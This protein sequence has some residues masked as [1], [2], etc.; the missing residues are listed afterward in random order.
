MKLEIL[1][2]LEYDKFAL[3]HK[4]I[5]I[6]QLSGWGKL[7]NKTGWKSHL[8][9]FKKNNEIICATLLLEKS[10]PIK[11]SLFYAPRGFLIDSDDFSLLNKFT[12]EVVKYI[13]L[14]KGFMLKIDPNVIYK[15]RNAKNE[16]IETNKNSF[17]NYCES[18]FKHFGFTQDF[19]TLQPRNLCRF[20]LQNSYEETLN[21]FQKSTRK[22]ILKAEEMGVNT[23]V[24]K[25]N[26]M[27]EF[28]RLLNM[29]G[30]KN[31]FIVR[32]KWYYELMKN[33]FNDEVVFYLTY[34]DV[35]KYLK[36]LQ[37]KI[38]ET[39]EKLDELKIKFEKYNVG[40]KLKKEKQN[41]E[42]SLIKYTDLL[43][44]EKEKYKNKDVVNIGALMSVFTGED[45]ITFMSGTDPEYKNFYPKYSYYNKHMEDS[46]KRK[47]K[48][49]NFYGISGNLEPN[50][51]Y[52]NIY[53]IKKGFNPDIVEL[54]GE[55]DFII[56]KFYYVLYKVALQAYK[57]VKKIKK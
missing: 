42:S 57:I 3:K 16:V 51:K 12:K 48:Y 43:K 8:V 23:K 35:K 18:G 22:N 2:E 39:K 15:I 19:E 34:L 47:M 46:L 53:E 13:K 29:A 6:Y 55:F 38:N 20:T 28:M 7:K 27:D 17:N 37:D 10:T 33:S 5:S 14:K 25:D 30:D 24:I 21:S 45:G 31:D 49:V 41:L 52:Y 56:N 32:P 11:K 50:S 54:I 44:I 40:D 9:G 36:Y 1:K 26:E 4:D